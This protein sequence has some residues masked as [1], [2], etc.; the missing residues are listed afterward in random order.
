MLSVAGAVAASSRASDDDDE[1]PG[2][3]PPEVAPDPALEAYVEQVAEHGADEPVVEADQPPECDDG[4]VLWH[5]DGLTD[6]CAPLCSTDADCIEGMER[7]AAL[8]VP[9]VVEPVTADEVVVD[10]NGEPVPAEARAFVDDDAVALE[11]AE[12]GHAIAVCDPFFDLN[13]ATETA[14][15]LGED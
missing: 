12:A 14:D 13:G 15:F 2:A 3:P 6:I 1:Q 4:E 11:S 7:C 10:E 8:V 5:R 9:Q